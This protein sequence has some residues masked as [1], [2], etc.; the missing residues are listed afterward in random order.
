MGVDDV[1]EAMASHP[2][3]QR[4]IGVIELPEPVVAADHATRVVNN[5]ILRKRCDHGFQVPLI[6]G[7]VEAVNQVDDVTAITRIDS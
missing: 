2:E 4:S 6:E 1:V 5:R 7:H 3:C